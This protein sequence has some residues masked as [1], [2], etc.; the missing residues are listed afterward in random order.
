MSGLA[1]KHEKIDG[2][3]EKLEAKDEKLE[4]NE[5]NENIEQKV[6]DEVRDKEAKKI[7]QLKKS[8]EDIIG[9]GR[10]KV[11]IIGKTGTGKST[12]CNVISG[13]P[14]NANLFPVS[15]EAV[16]CTQETQLA[17]VFFNNQIDKP[18]RKPFNIRQ[19]NIIFSFLGLFTHLIVSYNKVAF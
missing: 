13:L 14:H 19:T 16:S 7:I 4:M 3:E 17:D 8:N 10:Q 5:E 12:L 18:F 2:D 6:V 1:G 11:L 9:N 15:A